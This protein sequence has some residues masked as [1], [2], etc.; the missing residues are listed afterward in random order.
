MSNLFVL[1]ITASEVCGD[2]GI[3]PILEFVGVFV[4]ILK[5]AIPA[6]L[7]IFGTIDLGKAVIAQEE[8]KIKEAY[9]T[10]VKRAV[11]ALIVFFLPGIVVF[12]VNQFS[13]T[14]TQVGGNATTCVEKIFGQPIFGN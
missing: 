4:T 5:W 6:A 3:G 7:I 10:L 14:G 8:K 9:G 2:Q 12:L 1:A 11:A 13:T